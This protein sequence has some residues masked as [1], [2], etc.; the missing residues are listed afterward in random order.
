M[1]TSIVIPTW[2]A[3]GRGVELLTSLFGSIKRQTYSDYEVVVS[4]HSEGDGI[5][6]FCDNHE[7]DILYIK[8]PKI[9][10]IAQ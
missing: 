6:N 8:I 7:L 5:K 10:V 9:E 2:E 1:K 4:D 3:K